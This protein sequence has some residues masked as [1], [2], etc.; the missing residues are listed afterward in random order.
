MTWLKY[1]WDGI[2]VASSIISNFIPGS[3]RKRVKKEICEV[4]DRVVK[5]EQELTDILKRLKD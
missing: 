1:A 3:Q 5:V 4:R 2:K